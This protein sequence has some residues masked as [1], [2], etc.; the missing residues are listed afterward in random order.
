VIEEASG[1]SRRSVTLLRK[2]VSKKRKQP[3]IFV[4]MF[5]YR[6][7][8][9]RIM[10]IALLTLSFGGI[11]SMAEEYS[12]ATFAGGCFWCMTPPFE[13]LSGVKVVVSGYIGG[14][15]EN[16]TYED[17]AEKGYIEAVEIKF[18]P[19]KISYPELLNVFWKQID[20]TDGDGQFVDRGPQYR[21]A[22]FYYSDE[23]KEQALKSKEELSSSR[24]FSKP[25][26]TEVIKAA[27]FYPAEEYHQD[28][29]KKSPV[30]Y[31]YYRWNSGRD[32]YLKKIWGGK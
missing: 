21:S 18:D 28:Y 5:L 17:Y 9:K 6:Y 11:K 8:M 4:R 3:I 24:K 10:L 15:G 30:K 26:K 2:K 31:K 1:F 27:L 20:P 19:A 23:Q 13:K 16:P 12:L 7:N 14:V 29:Y 25:I 32:Q 22:V